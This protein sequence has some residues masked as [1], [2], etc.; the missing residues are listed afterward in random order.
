MNDKVSA[1]MLAVITLIVTLIVVATSW[2]V[3]LTY[4]ATMA[5]MWKF[6]FITTTVIVLSA[7]LM[8]VI[9]FIER[10]ER[11]EVDSL[12]RMLNEVN[13]WD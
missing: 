2:W 7:I 8:V 12:Q 4:L 3:A 10:K 1:F 11:Q 5:F 9:P 6:A 13:G